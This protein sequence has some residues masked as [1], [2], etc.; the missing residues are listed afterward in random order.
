MATHTVT[1]SMPVVVADRLV[2][3]AGTKRTD[4][5]RKAINQAVGEEIWT[6]QTGRPRGPLLILRRG[7]SMEDPAVRARMIE[8]LR[9]YGEA[10]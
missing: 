3:W 1:I 2:E 8:L 4:A 7:R 6:P 5:V 9:E 10:V